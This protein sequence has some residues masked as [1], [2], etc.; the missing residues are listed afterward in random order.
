MKKR[1]ILIMFSIFAVAKIAIGQSMHFSQFYNAPFL[2]SPAQTGFLQDNQYRVGFN[3]RNQWATI[4][5]NY[6]TFSVFA[7]AALNKGRWENSWLG[8]GIA[9][10]RDV[11]GDGKLALTKLQGN[12]AYHVMLGEKS[13]LSTGLGASYNQ[14]SVDISKLTFDMQ[15]NEISFDRN[16]PN[17][18][19]ISAQKT[20]FV[21]LNAGMNFAFTGE[22]FYLNVGISALHINQ[23]TETFYGMTNKLGLRP[24]L[25]LDVVYKASEK[26]M[27]QPM[28]YYTRQKKASILLG[29]SLFRFAVGDLSLSPDEFVIGAFYRNKD[30][31]IATVGYKRKRHQVMFSY[32]HTVSDLSNGNNGIGAFEISLILQGIKNSAESLNAYGCPRF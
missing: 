14:R 18:E 20:Q 30:A 12:I 17:G 9:A 22:I 31:A 2:L 16:I 29:G 24:Q 27:I 19:N 15:W 11:A 7:D 4:P 23:P 5:V 6:N 8:T 28:V 26:M 21:D 25:N 1:Y 10:Y 3:F 13:L 32:D